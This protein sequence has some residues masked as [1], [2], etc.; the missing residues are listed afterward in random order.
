MLATETALGY[1]LYMATTKTKRSTTVTV[2]PYEPETWS[3]QQL[4]AHRA[5]G[6]D[7]AFKAAS[8]LAAGWYR[9]AVTIDYRV[10]ESNDEE[11]MLRPSEVAVLDGWTPCYTVAAA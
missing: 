1:S 7:E 4:A 8:S 10:T 11:Y 5:S 6:L 2:F 9:R 3:A